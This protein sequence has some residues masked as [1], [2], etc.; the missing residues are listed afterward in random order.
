[1]VDAIKSLDTSKA[2]DLLKSGTCVKECPSAV[3][4]DPVRCK[5]TTSMKD[6]A[7]GF[8]TKYDVSA[9]PVWWPGGEYC[10][11]EI[12]LAYLDTYNIN[13][14][15][16]LGVPKDSLQTGQV[17]PFRYDTNR[18][19]GFCVPDFSGSG[20]SA[21][22]D[23]TIKT[24]KKHFNDTIMSDKVTSYLADIAQSWQVILISSITSILLGYIYLILIR[25]I[26]RFM[27]WF[28][29]ILIQLSLIGGGVY[30]YFESDTYE[31]TSDYRDWL[32]YAAYAIWGVAGLFLC[33]ICCC[34]NSI[35]IGIAVYETT[36]DYVSS[37]LRIFL[38]PLCAYFVCIIWFAGWLVS[39]VFVFSIGEP[40][41]RP[42]YEFITEM[43]WD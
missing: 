35:R 32:K 3:K 39:A 41:A 12:D 28:S 15:E 2:I 23:D 29:I 13:V 38:L 1:M 14:E 22:N 17:F 37:N 18:M 40:K 33:C 25:Y 9:D 11:Q 24:F 36:A 8:S 42:G 5:A 43:Q 21:I 7:N 19:Y 10:I 20:I 16:Y 31:E 30:M 26:G 4:A 34:W 6:P 27:I